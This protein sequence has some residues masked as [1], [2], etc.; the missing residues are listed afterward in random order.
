[1]SRQE[2]D[3]AALKRWLKDKQRGKKVR[4]SIKGGRVIVKTKVSRRLK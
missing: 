4:A 1:M 3:A 2:G